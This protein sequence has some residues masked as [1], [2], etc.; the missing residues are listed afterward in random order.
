MDLRGISLFPKSLF[1]SET[2][3]EAIDISLCTDGPL[4]PSFLPFYFRFS[5]PG[6]GYLPSQ[7]KRNRGIR[8]F[9]MWWRGG[10][11]RLYTG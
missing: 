7:K 9:L 5:E 11:L 8:F 3:C 6:T 10:V 4:L 1:Q 2:K